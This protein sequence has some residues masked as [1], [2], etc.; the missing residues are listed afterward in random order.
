MFSEFVVDAWKRCYSNNTADVFQPYLWENFD[1]NA[2]SF[3]HC[4][5]KYNDECKIDFMTMN[6]IGG[7]FQ[8][9]EG[10]RKHLFGVLLLFQEEK[11][12]SVSGVWFQHGQDLIFTVS[13]YFCDVST[14]LYI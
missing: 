14:S 7:F 13:V 5:Y 10:C 11:H 4:E 1:S 8:R 12:L 9:A 6:L 3:W 2:W